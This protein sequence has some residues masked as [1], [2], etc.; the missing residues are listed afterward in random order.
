MLD[1]CFGGGC[2]VDGYWVVSGGRW[3]GGGWVLGGGRVI[4]GWWVRVR[5]WVGLMGARWWLV[6]GWCVVDVG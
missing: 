2:V 1:G 6:D 4:R 5:W 3:C